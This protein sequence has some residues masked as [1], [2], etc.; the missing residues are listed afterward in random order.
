VTVGDGAA[1]GEPAMRGVLLGINGTAET[2]AYSIGGRVGG[3]ESPGCGRGVCEG[4]G[5][6]VIQASLRCSREPPGKK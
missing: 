4:R 5:V 2:G 1:V 3:M 6:G